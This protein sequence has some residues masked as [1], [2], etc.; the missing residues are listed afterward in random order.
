MENKAKQKEMWIQTQK[1]QEGE[2][3]LDSNSRKEGGKRRDGRLEDLEEGW[4]SRENGQ[5]EGL[6]EFKK[7]MKN[8]RLFSDRL[9]PQTAASRL[10][11]ERAVDIIW[12][13]DTSLGGALKLISPGLEWLWFCYEIYQ[14]MEPGSSNS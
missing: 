2:K 12:L 6:L 10:L 8:S 13:P 9:I 11:P 3:P 5:E 14:L 7:N 1:E 4:E